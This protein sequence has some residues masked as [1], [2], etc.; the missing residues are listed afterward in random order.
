MYKV[1]IDNKPLYLVDESFNSKGIKQSSLYVCENEEDRNEVLKILR[2]STPKKPVYAS[3]PSLEKLHD[4]FFGDFKKITAAG[5][6]VLNKRGEL[7]FIKRLGY[8]DLPKGKV[9]REE[10]L[11]EAAIREVEEEC[12]INGPVI[13]KKLTVTYHTYTAKNTDYLKATHWYLM[14]YDGEDEL[15]PQ[16]EEDITKAEWVSNQNSGK[17]LNTTYAS[18]EALI[19]LYS[20]TIFSVNKKE[21]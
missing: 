10:G 12:G 2:L 21:G 14:F 7:L 8:W 4:L 3:N 18:I 19:G 17:V 16:I 1:F 6:L 15:V 5:G 9:E 13:D 11:E 20:D